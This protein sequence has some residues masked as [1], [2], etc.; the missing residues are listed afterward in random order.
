VGVIGELYIGGDGLARGYLHREELTAERFVPHPYSRRGGERLYRSGDMVRYL[1]SGEIEF[2]GRRDEQ[3]KIRGYRIELGEIEAVLKKHSAVSEAVVLASEEESGEKRLVAYVVGASEVEVGE[4]RNYLK[5]RLPQYMVPS[6]Y[7]RMDEMP[8]TANG[9]VDRRALPA[10]ELS[11]AD[12]SAKFVAPRTPIEETLVGIWCKVLSTQQVSVDDNFFDLGGHSLLVTRVLNAVREIYSI[13]LP[14]RMFFESPTVAALAEQ[15]ETAQQPD[16]EME[17][18][19]LMLERLEH[20]SEDE[21]K[22][23]LELRGGEH[24]A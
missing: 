15:L 9:K 16:N 20:L 23:L 21:V 3:V 2:I 5:E 7:V 4:L 1:G 6:G 12:A 19:S 11:R 14:M 24:Q 8:L 22:E 13:D 17:R 18:V 10:Y